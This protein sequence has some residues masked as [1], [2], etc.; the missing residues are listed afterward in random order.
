[1]CIE[2][3]GTALKEEKKD[4]ESQKLANVFYDMTS[5]NKGGRLNEN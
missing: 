3:Y 4:N 2:L 5:L 1:M